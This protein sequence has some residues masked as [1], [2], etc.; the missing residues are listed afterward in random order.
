MHDW[1]GWA[2]SLFTRFTMIQPS[3]WLPRH[4]RVIQNLWDP[5]LSRMEKSGCCFV[6][7]LIVD[8]IKRRRTFSSLRPR[9][10]TCNPKVLHSYS[11]GCEF[12][13]PSTR[14]HVLDVYCAS[15]IHKYNTEVPT[16]DLRCVVLCNHPHVRFVFQT[17]HLH[18]QSTVTPTW[19]Q[20][21]HAVVLTC[22]NVKNRSR[23]S[24]FVLRKKYLHI[25]FKLSACR[26]HAHTMIHTHM[27]HE[28][29]KCLWDTPSACELPYYCTSICVRSCCNLRAS[30]VDSKT[31]PNQNDSNSPGNVSTNFS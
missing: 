6:L 29:R 17:R 16:N 14:Q 31:K 2:D 27:W 22:S 5:N 25:L 26:L 24:P 28:L 30:C 9:A 1:L 11:L 15:G 8:N 21:T 18:C 3:L 23:S 19:T 10:E 13:R 12:A 7:L 20:V 4:R